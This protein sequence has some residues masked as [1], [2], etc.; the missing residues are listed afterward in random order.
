MS[1]EWM[2][3]FEHEKC[4]QCHGCETACRSWRGLAPGV[5]YRRVLNVWRGA[6]PHVKSHSVA[7]GC[8]HCVEPAVCCGVPRRGRYQTQVGRPGSGVS[9]ALCTGCE[10]CLEACPYGVPQFGPE[11]IMGKCDLCREQAGREY[12]PPCVMTCPGGALSL[13][14]VTPGEKEEHQKTILSLMA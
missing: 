12:G 6:Y 1:T 2:I 8:L 14:E 5:S 3:L 4:T 9:E 7:L 10:A 13:R 11:G